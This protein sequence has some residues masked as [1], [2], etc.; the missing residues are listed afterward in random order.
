MLK[1]IAIVLWWIGASILALTAYG[2]FNHHMQMEGCAKIYTE[3]SEWERLRD[4]TIPKQRTK[5]ASI[6]EQMEQDAA[7][8]PQKRQGLDEAV[9]KCNYEK[10]DNGSWILI[11]YALPFFIVASFWADHLYAPQRPT[12]GTPRL[13]PL[14][15]AFVGKLLANTKY[16]NSKLSNSFASG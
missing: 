8:N 6:M 10:N 14:P 1:R 7:Y 4:A 13:S 16:E 11:I 5:A 3:E 9:T 15:T 2:I 12:N